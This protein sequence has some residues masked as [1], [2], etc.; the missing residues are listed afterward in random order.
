M[1][2][3]AVIHEYLASQLVAQIGVVT[4]GPLTGI[5]GQNFSNSI[6]QLFSTDRGQTMR[7]GPQVPFDRRCARNEIV[8]SVCEYQNCKLS[9]G[10]GVVSTD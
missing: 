3:R 2:R 9:C 10:Y 5:V 1:V 7:N 8:C 6:I 4:G